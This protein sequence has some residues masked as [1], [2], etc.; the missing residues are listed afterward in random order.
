MA[1]VCVC[2]AK[3]YFQLFM[4]LDVNVGIISELNNK[5]WYLQCTAAA[6]LTRCVNNACALIE[7]SINVPHIHTRG[8]ALTLVHYS[9]ETIDF[10]LLLLFSAF[11]LFAI[12]CE[13]L[14][15]FFE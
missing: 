6:T 7:D 10:G 3:C 8:D 15:F 12:E 9:H 2:A 13:I 14:L 11:F 5:R 4:P 1:T